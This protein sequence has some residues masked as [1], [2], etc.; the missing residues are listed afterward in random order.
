IDVSSGADHLQGTI[1]TPQA[2]PVTSPD[3]TVAF[4]A[5]AAPNGLVDVRWGGSL[6]DSAQV[7]SKDFRW[8]P[9]ADPGR[10]SVPGTIFVDTTQ[11][12]RITREN[13]TKLAGGV[14]GSELTAS[15]QTS[16]QV[17]VLHPF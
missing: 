1:E 9:M 14:T 12:I 3:P 13:S 16:T 6:A 11:Q 15:I 10:L 2:A 7:D 17:L 5:H 8:G 4:D